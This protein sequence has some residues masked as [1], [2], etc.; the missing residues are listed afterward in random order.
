MDLSENLGYRVR[1][2]SPRNR[3]VC[4]YKNRI[5]TYNVPQHRW[6]SSFHKT[7]NFRVMPTISATTK[8]RVPACSSDMGRKLRMTLARK[9]LGGS[10][11]SLMPFC[12]TGTGKYA[13]G[14]T[15][16]F[17][18][19]SHV[20]LGV[21]TL[22]TIWTMMNYE[23]EPWWNMEHWHRQQWIFKNFHGFSIIMSHTWMPFVKLGRTIFQGGG[24]LVRK[25]RKSLWV[26]EGLGPSWGIIG[27]VESKAGE[28][29]E[30]CRIII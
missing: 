20:V 18:N 12:S 4:L 26:M 7:G 27:Q 15:S 2:A 3:W 25:S 5:H 1:S 13:A 24:M 10:V 6:S 23:Y 11:V 30:S 29:V 8:C 16:A 28:L 22:S 9:P 14:L 19:M 17:R 21:Q